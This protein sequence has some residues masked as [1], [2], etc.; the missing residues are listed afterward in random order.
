[1]NYLRTIFF[2]VLVGLASSHIHAVEEGD[3]AIDFNLPLLEGHSAGKSVNLSDYKGKLIYVD[4]WASWCGP[5]RKS[6]P[7]LE[8]LRQQYHE[9]GFEVIAINVD[10]DLD[11]ALGFLEKYPVSYPVV[12]DPQGT[13]PE[14]YQILGMPTA[15]LVDTDGTIVYRHVGFR[16]GDEKEVEEKINKYL[17]GGK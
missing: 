4:F 10:E 16:K 14:Q 2:S 7:Q 6:L 8:K 17:A 15:Y 12:L 3:A 9:Q 13:M 5:C 11:D 1:M